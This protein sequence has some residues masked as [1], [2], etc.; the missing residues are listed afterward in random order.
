VKAVNIDD[1]M[2]HY[3][4]TSEMPASSLEFNE[5]G[6]SVTTIHET[7]W[8]R[9]LLTRKRT[10]PKGALLEI[11]ISPPSSGPGPDSDSH[12]KEETGE[13]GEATRR[14]I[15][16]LAKHVEY[17]LRLHD[18]GFILDM[19]GTECTWTA[20]GIFRSMPSRSLFELIAPP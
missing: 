2:R 20:Y 12:K 1:I 5:D 15:L 8:V 19:L 3:R 16:D 11:E 18:A 10:D 9:I 13:T 14:R 6:D 17:M 7:S 4:E